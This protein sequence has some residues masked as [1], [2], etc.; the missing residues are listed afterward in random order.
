MADADH[1]PQR[2]GSEGSL[3]PGDGFLKA[4][5]T[6]RG[7]AQKTQDPML[8]DDYL[9]AARTFEEIHEK[10]QRVFADASE[11]IAKNRAYAESLQRKQYTHRHW[12]FW[13][14]L[15]ILLLA[16]LLSWR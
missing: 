6:L 10:A 3:D 11:S 4:A 16:W 15:T 5:Q 2:N 8:Q 1:E 7:H 9:K 12:I 13:L 14:V